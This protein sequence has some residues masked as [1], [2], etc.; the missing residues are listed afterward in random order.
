M[1]DPTKTIPIVREPYYYHS[2][3]ELA[4]PSVGHR[5]SSSVL[6]D[7]ILFTMVAHDLGSTTGS[8]IGLTLRVTTLSNPPL[9]HT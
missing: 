2:R 8:I 3:A 6:R 4:E 7:H 9:G 1:V 5:G